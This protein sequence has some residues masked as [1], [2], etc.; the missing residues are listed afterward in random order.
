MKTCDLPVKIKILKAHRAARGRDWQRIK[1]ARVT[2]GCLQIRAKDL[3]PRQHIAPFPL[4]ATAGDGTLS[5]VPPAKF[6]W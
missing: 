1:A 6:G 5:T 3:A 2:L 4:F